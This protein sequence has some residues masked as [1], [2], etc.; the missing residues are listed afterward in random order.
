MNGRATR[1][2]LRYRIRPTLRF[3]SEIVCAAN[4]ACARQTHL[5]RVIAMAGQVLAEVDIFHVDGI[6]ADMREKQH[7]ST[8]QEGKRASNEERVTSCSDLVVAGILL[9]RVERVRAGEGSDFAHGGCE[10]VVL[11][12]AQKSIYKHAAGSGIL[13]DTGCTRFRCNKANVIARSELAQHEEDSIH[14]NEAANV[15]GLGKPWI[16]ARHDESN[17]AL[18]HNTNEERFLW[19]H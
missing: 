18:Q 17:D 14:N 13:P 11:P 12:S 9:Y 1:V 16:T 4:I 3:C 8:R 5:A 19:P 15:L 6:L 10:T 2:T 7:Q